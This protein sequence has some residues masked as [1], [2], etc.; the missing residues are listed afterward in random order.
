MELSSDPLISLSLPLKWLHPNLHN[1]EPQPVFV[2]ID[3][4]PWHD[5][6]YTLPQQKHNFSEVAILFGR[7][8]G[9]CYSQEYFPFAW[10]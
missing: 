8:L 5:T 9:Q 4:C 7:N 6:M 1:K 2:S 10:Q 3:I